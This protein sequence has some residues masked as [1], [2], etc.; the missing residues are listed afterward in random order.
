MLDATE[1]FKRLVQTTLGV[2]LDAPV[3]RAFKAVSY[4]R[5]VR[6][7]ALSAVP[8]LQLMEDESDVATAAAELAE[9]E[10]KLQAR[11][12]GSSTTKRANQSLGWSKDAPAYQQLLTNEAAKGVVNSRLKSVGLIAG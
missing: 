9:F 4:D 3:P 11:K 6:E 2:S 5:K 10:S 8:D 12:S 1:T 7:A